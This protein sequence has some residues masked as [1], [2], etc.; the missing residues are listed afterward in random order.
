MRLLTANRFVAILLFLVL[1][2]GGGNLW[3]THAQIDANNAAQRQQQREQQR[4]G[5]RELGLICTTFA[6]LAV[7][8]PPPGSAKLN[9]SRAYEQE[10]HAT[11][12][13]LGPDLGCK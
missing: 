12:D 4:E 10:L 1:I 2:V 7:L 11:L 13:E 6:R 3:A 8:K 9:P 5:R